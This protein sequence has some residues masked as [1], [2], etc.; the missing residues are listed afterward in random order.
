MERASRGGGEGPPCCMIAP[1]H[2]LMESGVG[3]ITPSCGRTLRM[4]A[5]SCSGW[6]RATSVI[7]LAAAL[8][9]ASLDPSAQ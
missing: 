8:R 9:V 4:M 6:L 2:M 3:P 1:P 7:C 5:G